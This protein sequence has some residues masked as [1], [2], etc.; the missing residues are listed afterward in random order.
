MRARSDTPW[1]VVVVGAGITGVA[2]GLALH[3]A[4]LRVRV[5]D[6]AVAPPFVPDPAFD[7]RIYA[8]SAASQSFLARVGGWQAMDAA[9]IEPIRAMD[10]QGDGQ[11]RLHFDAAGADRP[12]GYIAESAALLDGLLAVVRRTAPDLVEAPVSVR[13]ET[14]VAGETAPRR[15]HITLHCAASPSTATTTYRTRLLV[16]ADGLQSSLREQL[17]IAAHFRPYGQTAVVANYE[18]DLAHGGVARQWFLQ[19][20]VVAL[21]PLPGNLVSLVWS[22]R[23]EHAQTLLALTP[24]E[25]T[26]ALQAVVGYG[27]GTLVE[28]SRPA[29][30]PLRWM[31][32]ERLTAPRAVLVGDA[33]HGVHPM[34]GQGL[35][36]GL[37]DA[38]TLAELLIHR[39]EGPDC[40]DAGLLRRYA[41]ARVEPVWA[42]Q[43][44]TDGL[45]RLF[46]EARWGLPFARNWGMSQVDRL[47]GLKR[48]LINQANR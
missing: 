23:E 31:R 30:F 44:L 1:D 35:N 6:R 22:A 19:G 14:G 11:G 21:L 4:G 34:A 24:Q 16:A 42:M 38:A 47:S 2:L 33:A 18:S 41:R 5:L 9:R 8:L 3:Q 45:Y 48:L 32:A 25:R 43:G 15:D 36:L 26:A 29:G 17:G 20:E 12:L 39:G 13:L 7:P 10:I 40:G 27:V 46:G 37:Q 28:R